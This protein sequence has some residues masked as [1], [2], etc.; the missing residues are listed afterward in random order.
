MLND[1]HIK[2]LIDVIIRLW[3]A[4]CNKESLSEDELCQIIMV[5]YPEEDLPDGVRSPPPS[6]PVIFTLGA[7][8][9][10]S[11]ASQVH[12]F[13]LIYLIRS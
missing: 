2:K 3:S 9:D 5:Q 12:I 6:T 4:V 1:T 13:C 11:S 8:S 10:F 7:P